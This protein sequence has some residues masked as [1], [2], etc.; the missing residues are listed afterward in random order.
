[1]SIQL[2]DIS[3]LS[4]NYSL[5]VSAKYFTKRNPDELSVTQNIADEKKSGL[6]FFSSFM[7]FYVIILSTFS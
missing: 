3:P 1:M 4:M 7:Y 2:N 5:M 6:P